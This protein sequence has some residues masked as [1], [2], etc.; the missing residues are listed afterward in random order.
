MIVIGESLFDE[1][2]LKFMVEDMQIFFELNWVFDTSRL[3]IMIDILVSKLFQS[4]M[5]QIVLRSSYL[6]PLVFIV[7]C[8]ESQLLQV[9]MAYLVFICLIKHE[10]KHL[11]CTIL[12][13]H[14]YFPQIMSNHLIHG[15][16][17]SERRHHY[18]V[19]YSQVKVFLVV[20]IGAEFMFFAS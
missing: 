4:Q 8:I 11:F 1:A 20:V 7:N 2:L 12:T 17:C 14:E 18:Q 13:L 16:V 19:P 15:R 3:Q 9:L 6:L 10:M 5:S